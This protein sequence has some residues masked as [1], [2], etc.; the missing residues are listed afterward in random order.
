[1]R[2]P[3]SKVMVTSSV[4]G[5]PRIGSTQRLG[6]TV[7][8]VSQVRI[9]RSKRLLKPTGLANLARTVLIC[10]GIPFSLTVTAR[11]LFVAVVVCGGGRGGL[12]GMPLIFSLTVT[13][14]GLF[15]ALVVCGG[16]PLR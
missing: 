6:V 1:M 11:G 14:R 8:C 13:A 12:F 15:V 7:T 9:V 5:F 16:F 2:L 4:L 3:L 10:G